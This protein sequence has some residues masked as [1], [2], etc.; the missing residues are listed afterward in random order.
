MTLAIEFNIEDG[1]WAAAAPWYRELALRG[2]ELALR[3]AGVAP[4]DVEIS[5]LLCGDARIAALNEA[6]RGRAAPTNVLSWPA[7]DLAPPAPG[8]PP[9][10]PPDGELGDIALARETIEKEAMERHLT[11]EAHFAHLFIHGVLH[12]LGYAH[13]TDDDAALME[14]LEREALAAMGIDDPYG[15]EGEPRQGAAGPSPCVT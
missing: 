1:G 3:A 6:H 12:L 5:A 4:H 7:H 9:P 8:A 2:A 15:G 14:G 11:V 10:P 13:E